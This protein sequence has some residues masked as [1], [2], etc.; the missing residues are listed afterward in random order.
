MG[1]LLP[2]YIDADGV[3]GY[4][5]RADTDEGADTGIRYSFHRYRYKIWIQIQI[6]DTD[7]IQV[8]A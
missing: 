6:K 2:V 4:R 5:Y 7:Q 1:H 3:S 8:Q